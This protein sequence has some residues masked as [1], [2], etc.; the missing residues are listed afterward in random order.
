MSWHYALLL[1]MFYHV[2]LSVVRC[3]HGSNL[4]YERYDISFYSFKH[5]DTSLYSYI[6]HGAFLVAGLDKRNLTR[7]GAISFSPQRETRGRKGCGAL[8]HV[9]C[10]IKVHASTQRRVSWASPSPIGG[11]DRNSSSVCDRS[12]RVIPIHTAGILRLMGIFASVL[13]A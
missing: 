2:A 5:C 10:A 3:H 6:R 9:Y 7:I 4:F 12:T 11:T 1:A 13:E 8:A